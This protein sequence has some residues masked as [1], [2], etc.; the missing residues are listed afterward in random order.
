MGTRKIVNAGNVVVPAILALEQQ[1]FSVSV[2]EDAGNQT[3]I[4]ERSLETYVANDPVALLGLARLIELR[5]W[6][7]QATDSEIEDVIQKYQQG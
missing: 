2:R 3:F 7:W 6:E 4:A 5:G 1:G